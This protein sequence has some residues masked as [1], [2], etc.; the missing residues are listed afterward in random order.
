MLVLLINN[1]MIETKAPNC[2]F[3]AFVLINPLPIP[4]QRREN[5]FTN[6]DSL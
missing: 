3:G 6:N 1:N 2:K 5:N 4:L